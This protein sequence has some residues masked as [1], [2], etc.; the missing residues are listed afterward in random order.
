LG[1]SGALVTPLDLW[2]LGQRTIKHDPLA[3][4]SGTTTA[5][6]DERHLSERRGADGGHG[7]QPVGQY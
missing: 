6:V 2:E 5:R 3:R 1:N 7:S 4:R